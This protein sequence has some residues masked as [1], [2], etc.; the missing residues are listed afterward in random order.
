MTETADTKVK[1]RGVWITA[2]Q[3]DAFIWAEE[4]FH[5]RHP[6]V[7]F[8]PVQGSWSTNV[9]A[10]AGTHNGAGATDW[11]TWHMTTAQRIHMIVCL[12][13]AGQAVW[14][15]T[16]VS[17]FDPHAHCLDR[18]TR[19]MSNLAKW[20]VEQYDAG[21]SGLSSNAKDPTY[22]PDPPRKWSYKL[23]RPI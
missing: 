5:E 1:W 2:R 3:R 11:R 16:R 9:D 7:D 21:R 20:Q 8:I 15:R 19:G 18:V 23:K 13:N 22:R 4:Q 12:K 10:S 14:Y 17:G 6:N